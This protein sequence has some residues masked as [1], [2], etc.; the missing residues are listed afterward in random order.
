[1][2]RARRSSD[3]VPLRSSSAST[4][5]QCSASQARAPRETPPSDRAARRP[6][7]HRSARKAAPP[8]RQATRGANC[9]WARTARMRLPCSMTLRVRSST[10][11]PKRVNTSS[12]RNCAYSSRRLSDSGLEDRC[13][14][15]AADARHALA[16]VDRRLLV[17]VEKTRIEINLTVG[18]RDQ[19]GWNIRADIAGLGLGDRQ[20]RQRA[21]AA[22]QVRASL[23]VREDANGCRKY[24]RDRPRVRAAGAAA[25]ILCR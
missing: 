14:R 1:M 3:R 22:A 17:F 18:D 12:S 19:I 20:R 24:R 10:M 2:S 23:P 21:A 13:L 6:A 4:S 8:V 25:V 5:E 11:V 15:L 16:D 9:R 7:R